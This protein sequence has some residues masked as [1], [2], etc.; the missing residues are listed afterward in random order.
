MSERIGLLFADSSIL[1]LSEGTTVETA[2]KEAEEH[3]F[4]NPDPETRV[5]RLVLSIAEVITEGGQVFRMPCCE[6]HNAASVRF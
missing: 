6:A 3:D 5:V 1:V 2:K 4:G